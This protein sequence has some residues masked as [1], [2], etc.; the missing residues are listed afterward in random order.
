VRLV[1]APGDRAHVAARLLRLPAVDAAGWVERTE[2]Q[3]VEFVRRAFGQDPAD[4]IHY[5][6]VL[7][8]SRL[9]V[10]EAAEAVVGVLRG[11]EGRGAPAGEKAEPA[12]PP[13]ARAAIPATV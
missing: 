4:P 13:E 9:S 11:F 7:N 6:L 5:D 10:A 12:A 1:A 8:M 3:R 2:R